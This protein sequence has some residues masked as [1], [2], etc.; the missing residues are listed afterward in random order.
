MFYS[1][2]LLNAPFTLI[3][4]TISS[5]SHPI[6]FFL[7]LQTTQYGWLP[8][9]NLY[10]FRFGYFGKMT[11]QERIMSV[12]YSSSIAQLNLK[13]LLKLSPLPQTIQYWCHVK[14][15]G[16]GWNSFKNPWPLGWE[17][18]TLTTTLPLPQNNASLVG[19]HVRI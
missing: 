13:S 14:K 4:Y 7:I 6:H 9:T 2:Y 12:N 3:S 8:F 11:D 10:I 19:L 17:A 16:N 18:N 5:A 1:K 15:H